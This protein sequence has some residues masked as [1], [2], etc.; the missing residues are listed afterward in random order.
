VA[1]FRLDKDQFL[2]QLNELKQAGDEY[3]AAKQEMNLAV[4]QASQGI[5]NAQGASGGGQYST[6]KELQQF[7]R[8]AHVS[9]VSLDSEMA[10]LSTEQEETIEDLRW[11]VDSFEFEDE[12]ER[13]DILNTLDGLSEK[14]SYSSPDGMKKIHNA[15][16]G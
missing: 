10:I 1:I 13:Q 4:D 11:S 14:F 16:N 9:L 6:L 8:P 7:G 15:L 12:A 5:D 2:R 3:V